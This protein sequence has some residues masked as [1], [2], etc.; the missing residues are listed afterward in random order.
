MKFNEFINRF[1]TSYY[2]DINE[3]EEFDK[4]VKEKIQEEKKDIVDDDYANKLANYF[5]KNKP[6]YIVVQEQEEYLEPFYIN[7]DDKKSKKI[8]RLIIAIASFIAISYTIFTVSTKKDKIDTKNIL[9]TFTEEQEED[10]ISGEELYKI[11]V[12]YAKDN[13]LAISKENYI[14]FVETFKDYFNEGGTYKPKGEQR[15]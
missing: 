2:G 9:G 3:E 11:F 5:S 7:N 1:T 13:D 15:P 4:M 10:Q 6:N 12:Q 8:K 14:Y